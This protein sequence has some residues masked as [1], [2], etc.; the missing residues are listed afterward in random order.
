MVILLKVFNSRI[1]TA[2][3]EDFLINEYCKN[4]KLLSF[5]TYVD[6]IESE[7]SGDEQGIG[8]SRCRPVVEHRVDLSFMLQDFFFVTATEGK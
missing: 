1:L 6:F 7:F 3:L 5:P 4:A 8:D 2:K